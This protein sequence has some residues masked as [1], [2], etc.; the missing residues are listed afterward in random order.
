LSSKDRFQV[1]GEKRPTTVTE[2][3]QE[4]IDPFIGPRPFRRE[5]QKLFFGRDKETNEILSLVFAHQLVL[6]YA[7]SGAGKTSILNAQVTPALEKYGYN[8]LPTARVGIAS[9]TKVGSKKFDSTTKDNLTS[10]NQVNFYM[11]NALQSLKPEANPQLFLN[12]SLSEFLN[13][14]FPNKKEIGVKLKPQVLAFDQLEEIFR[15]YPNDSWREQQEDFFKQVAEALEKDPLLRIVFV[16]RE[17]YLAELDHF[18]DILPERLRPRFRLERLRKDAAFKAIKGPLERTNINLV[19]SPDTKQINEHIGDLVN[20][21]LK[22]R[23]EDPLTG[24]PQEL[25]GEFIEPIQLQVVCRR[26]WREKLSSRKTDS[27]TQVQLEKSLTNVDSALR[28]FYEEAIHGAV[29]KTRISEDTIRRWFDEKFITASGTRAFVHHKAFVQGNKNSKDKEI[30]ERA[31]GSLEESYIIRAEWRSGAKW[32]EL[33]HDRLIGPIKDSNKQWQFEMEKEANRFT[34]RKFIRKK[35]YCP[36]VNNKKSIAIVVT[37]AVVAAVLVNLYI[38]YIADPNNQPIIIPPI[39]T[40]DVG[41]LPSFVSVNPNTNLVYVTNYLS[42]TISVINGTINN[43]VST[44]PIGNRP[45]DVAVNPNT[46]LVYVTH[47]FDNTVSVIDVIDNTVSVIDAASSIAVDE[48]PRGVAVN[49]NTNLVYVTNFKD[50]T[51]SV[52]DGTTNNIVVQNLPVGLS[53]NGVAVNPNTNLVYVTNFIDNTVSVIDGKTNNIIDTIPIGNRPYDVAVNP[54]TNLVY[55]TNLLSNTTS[56][57]NGTT[58]NIVQN[59]TIGGRPLGIAV[60]PNTNLVYVANKD[61]NTIS[62]IDGNVINGTT[63]NIVQN[64][65]VGASPR[66][67]AVNPNTNIVYAANTNDNTLTVINTAKYLPTTIQVGKTPYAIAVNPTTNLVYVAN[68]DSNTIY[69][70]N[71]TTNTVVQNLPVDEGPIDVAVN[72]N[73]N[74]IYVANLFSN[75]MSVINGTTNNIVVQNLPV[76][77]SPRGVAVNPNTN[78]VYVTNL[79]SDTISVID[80]K[81]NEVLNNITVGAGPIGVAVNPNTNL[82]YVTNLDSDTISVI[83]GTTNSIVQTL[84]AGNSPSAIDLDVNSGRIYVVNRDDNSLKIITLE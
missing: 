42:D 54:N 35:F 62:V 36:L 15:F 65:P 47:G 80:G 2:E 41:Q 61:S 59:L 14:Y 49:P 45:Y 25:K 83:D 13:E 72:P 71:G 18:V 68:V 51:V 37:I 69:S 77:A 43:V 23:V 16:I 7:Q 70:I 44:I 82:V 29:E 12:K 4:I 58:N 73:T 1:Y 60:N 46:N 81:T 67:V 40:I 84:A 66:G 8:V 27:Q 39:S 24:E 74:T 6:I 17:D 76:G 21:L 53:P 75:T 79:D 34:L 56:V 22:I 63:N 33:T 28:D 30:I 31:I 26:W 9:D 52:I 5:D 50:N 11:F 64:L 48:S 78:L 3:E 19:Q 10:G 57:I 20:D 32:Y 55:V 38:A